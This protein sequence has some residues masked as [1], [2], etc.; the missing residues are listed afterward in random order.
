MATLLS[1][2]PTA[3]NRLTKAMERQIAK[4]ENPAREPMERW[5]TMV[6]KNNY[7]NS[8]AINLFPAI[9]PLFP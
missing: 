3:F 4:N 9:Y 5:M 8:N 7:F 6:L 2:S 1:N